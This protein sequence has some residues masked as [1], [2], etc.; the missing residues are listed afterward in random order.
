LIIPVKLGN[1]AI[2]PNDKKTVLVADD[3]ETFQMF[4]NILLR[5]MGFH[6]VT[7]D[8]GEEAVRLARLVGPHLIT[9]D[10]EMPKMN[11]AEALAGIR[12]D[13]S[14]RDV[15][16]VIISANSKE[17][18]AQ[19]C[20]GS[21][22]YSYLAKPV[23]VAELNRIVQ[24]SL[25]APLGRER[26]YLR[27]DVDLEVSLGYDGSVSS[28]KAETLSERGVYLR[29]DDALP[30]GAGVD[31]ALYLGRVKMDLTGTVIY[32]KPAKAGSTTASN[33]VAIEF[34]SVGFR[35]AATLKDYIVGVLTEGI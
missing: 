18:V 33:G 30:V 14:L 8:D 27:I 11:G 6:V 29:M 3:S 22:R 9:L 10:M 17:D 20:D 1:I 24:E 26:K 16:V 21:G 25:Y 13:D 28:Y 7:A 32:A 4:L 19:R 2:M 23:N 35:E 34:N 12:K 15:P 31:V 5:R